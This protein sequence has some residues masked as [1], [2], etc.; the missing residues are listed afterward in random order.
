LSRTLVITA[1]LVMLA[2][3]ARAAGRDPW[4]G[5]D[6]ALHFAASFTIAGIGYAFASDVTSHR[7]ARIATAL[8]LALAAGLAKEGLDALGYG[9]PSVRDLAWDAIGSVTGTAAA[10]GIDLLFS[11]PPPEIAWAPPGPLG[12]ARLDPSTPL[13]AR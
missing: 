7:P 11:P 2:T 6:K 12:W 3:P 9:D 13:A 1:A 8:G 10:W 4:L 5:R